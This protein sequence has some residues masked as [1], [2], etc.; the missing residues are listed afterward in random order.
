MDSEQQPSTLLGSLGWG[1]VRGAEVYDFVRA[2]GECR[3]RLY[4]EV[5]PVDKG[6]TS[7]KGSA[8]VGRGQRPHSRA[9]LAE[10]IGHAGVFAREPPVRSPSD[11]GGHPETANS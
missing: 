6:W 2:P 1:G 5:V 10:P 7:S 11:P 8:W 9:S 4:A 3:M